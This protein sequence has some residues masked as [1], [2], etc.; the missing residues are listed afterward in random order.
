MSSSNL[1][2]RHIG[3]RDCWPA[4]TPSVPA[5]SGGGRRTVSYPVLSVG[6]SS[7]IYVCG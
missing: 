4:T 5:A 2:L 6:R 1:L 3:N 7:I